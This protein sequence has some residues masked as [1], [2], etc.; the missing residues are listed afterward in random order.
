MT[1]REMTEE[2]EQELELAREWATTTRRL[3]GQAED[4][5]ALALMRYNRQ[6]GR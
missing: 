1:D 6:T 3:A 4:Q 2:R 5:L